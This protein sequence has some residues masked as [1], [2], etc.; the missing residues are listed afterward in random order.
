M[1]LSNKKTRRSG[2]SPHKGNAEAFAIARG[3]CKI[4]IIFLIHKIFRKKLP[5]GQKNVCHIEYFL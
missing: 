4:N 2:L 3:Q 1:I 5:F